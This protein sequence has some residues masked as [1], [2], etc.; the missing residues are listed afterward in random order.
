MLPIECVVRGYLAGS[1]LEGLP[2][3]RRGL[4]PSPP[5]RAGRERA[6]ARADLHAGDEGDDRPR[7]EHR[8][9]DGGRRSSARSAS[10]RSRR[11]RSS[12]TASPPT[13]ALERGIILADTK[14]EFGVDETG[15]LVLA[16]EAFTPDSSRFW[17]ADEYAPGGRTAVVRQAVR[18]RL[19]RVARLGQDRPRPGAAGRGRR[20]HPAPLRRGVRAPDR[21]RLR[22]VR[23]T[24]RA[25]CSNE[26]DRARPAR[27][28]GS[29]TR[30]AR[31]SRAR[32]GTSASTSAR[33]A[34]RQGRRRRARDRRPGRGAQR[35]WRRCASSCSPTR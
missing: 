27:S 20:G 12:S 13:H 31:P 15:T 1:G 18:A 24:T 16:D 5:G 6:A 25:W 22:R 2:G 33:H 10:T 14:L 26:G 7:R 19:L 30:R 28:R 9:R 3:D 17:P 29:S 35:S 21:D 8:P 32:S 4:R 34:D 23:R 11:S